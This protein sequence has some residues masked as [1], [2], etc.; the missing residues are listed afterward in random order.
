MAAEYGQNPAVWVRLSLR[1]FDDGLRQRPAVGFDQ[2]DVAHGF[3]KALV[4]HPKRMASGVDAEQGR[5]GPE[6]VAQDVPAFLRQRP[7]RL[8]IMSGAQRT[9]LS[10]LGE[11]SRSC[12]TNPVRLPLASSL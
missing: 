12:S 1:S 11:P 9:W 10:V 3:V 4:A 7:A 5:M 2:V 8:K 6:G